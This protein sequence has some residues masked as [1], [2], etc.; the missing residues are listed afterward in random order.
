MTKT[1]MCPQC[2]APIEE[3]Y[4]H[5]AMRDEVASVFCEKCGVFDIPLRD[6]TIIVARPCPKCES[7]TMQLL[8]KEEQWCETH[9]FHYG[10]LYTFECVQCHAHDSNTVRLGWCD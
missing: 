6:I 9:H 5:V 10:D 7:K 1:A 4:I 3:H 8:K 2:Y